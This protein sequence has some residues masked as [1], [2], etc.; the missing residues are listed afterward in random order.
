VATGAPARRSRARRCGAALAR[1]GADAGADAVRRWRCA[2]AAQA[3]LCR[4][5]SASASGWPSATSC[6]GSSTAS[7]WC[8]APPRSATLTLTPCAHAYAHPRVFA[9]FQV[10]APISIPLAKAR[11]RLRQRTH[12]QP[13]LTRAPVLPP[14]A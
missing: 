5:P 6:A 3:R 13:Q 10:T 12:A 11:S 8:V 7:S 2:A 9:L 4:R 1:M 14:A